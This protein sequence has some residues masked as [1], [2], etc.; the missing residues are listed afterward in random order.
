[1]FEIIFSGGVEDVEDV[2]IVLD[3][4]EDGIKFVYVVWK[5]LV[6]LGCF[7]IWL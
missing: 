1:M 3:E 4:V 2:F 6:F 7:R 5:L